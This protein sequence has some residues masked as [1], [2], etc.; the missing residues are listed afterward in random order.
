MG[1]VEG[2]GDIVFGTSVHELG[3]GNGVPAKADDALEV[4]EGDAEFHLTINF[5]GDGGPVFFQEG[6]FGGDEEGV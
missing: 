5:D 3:G 4:V 6:V 2:E 1:I